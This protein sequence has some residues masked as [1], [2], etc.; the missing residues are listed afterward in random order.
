MTLIIKASL[1]TAALLCVFDPTSSALARSRTVDLL[2][3]GGLVYDGGLGA[4]VIED[5]GVSG[6][7]VVFVG[8]AGKAG[9]TARR[10]L[11]A[12]GMMVTPGF[13]DAHTHTVD[14]LA[15]KDRSQRLVERQVSQG[16]TTS[17]I[18]VDGEGPP[19]IKA[20]LGG[21]ET[22]GIGQNVAAYVGF[23]AIRERVL[24]EQG[25]ASTNAELQTMKGLA[26]EGMCEG[27]LGLSSGLFY[28][29]QSFAATEEVIAVAKEAGKRGGLYDTHQRDE[30]DSS[31][32]VVTSLREA[33]RIGQESGAPLHLAHIKVSGGS[34]PNG[35]SMI[36]LLD[37]IKAAQASG[38]PVTADQYPWSAANT[39][40]VDAIIP[41][42]AQ[43]GGRD[44]MLKRFENPAD[45]AKIKAQDHLNSQIAQAVMIDN[46]PSEPAI[47]G[48]RLS[49]LSASW[50]VDPTDAV[51]AIL[52][53]NENVS[54]AVFVM[55]EPDIKAAMA[56]P[57][58]MSSSDGRSGGHPRAY[59]TFPRLWV[60]YVMEQHVLTPVQ[61]V[62][63]STGLP[64][65]TF[66][67]K[68]RGYLKVGSFADIAVISPKTY[69]ANATYAEP[70]RLSTGV[71]DV[72][73]NGGVEYEHGRPTGV[74]S[75]RGLFKTPPSG[76]CP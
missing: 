41:R 34:K 59:A 2:V 64:A 9:V 8:D 45:V 40:L 25:R 15:S 35:A 36:E 33:I 58:V 74:L 23:G 55:T 46:A 24:G 22:S 38:Q 29:P 73:V 7:K 11:I 50:G 4:P 18:G 5:I 1:C 20:E 42:W 19:E 65:D 21:F 72:V 47:V 10:T 62:H 43:D 70:K 14:E 16:V 60:N 49:E 69:Q 3:V 56:E 17:I 51:I 12:S 67:L 71:E 39:G 75:G 37:L 66:G 44:A 63:R 30:G 32:G 52:K 6:D 68:G 57:W 76:T 13:I 53:R 48:K 26:A 61:F 27:A 28:A 31:V 54:V